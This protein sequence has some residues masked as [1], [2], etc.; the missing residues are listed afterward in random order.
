MSD[1]SPIVRPQSL[2]A[3]VAIIDGFS[4]S[5]KSLVA[6]LM[7][8]FQR[9]E[10]WLAN[11]SYEYLCILDHLGLVEDSVATTMPNYLA[12]WDTYHLLIG[13]GVNYRK[14]D[15][16]SAQKNGLKAVYD[17]R[18]KGPEG[19]SILKA[20][21]QTKPILNLMTHYIYGIS[22]PLFT[23]LGN[24]LK[25]CVVTDRHP[26]WLV[27][28]WFRGNWDRRIGK[29]SREF[30]LCIRSR[31]QTVPWFVKGWETQYLK[32]NAMEKSIAVIDLFNRSFQKRYRLMNAK[33]KN[34]SVFIP[35]EK[36]IVSPGLYI[37][38]L[39]RLMGTRRT[40]LTT[41]LCEKFG[42][43]RK[44]SS[45]DVDAQRERIEAL[46]KRYSVSVSYRRQFARMCK[47]YE[48]Q[49]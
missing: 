49:Y 9:S 24:R 37:E 28:G 16:S 40:R 12:D 25:V 22:Q 20:A 39:A 29:D 34:R 36:F 10:V 26:L 33:D 30:Q 2:I 3:D 13:R 35:F 47:A 8:S 43:P 46:F 31:R 11:Y 15:A 4:G 18:L 7:S 6:P 45:K 38:K 14:T 48:E 23:A 5:G 17:G 42:L 27:E 44:F 21:R 19:D 32:A 1:R 41:Q